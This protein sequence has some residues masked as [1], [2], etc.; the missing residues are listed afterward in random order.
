M[1]IAVILAVVLSLSGCAGPEGEP[2]AMGPPGEQGEQG[3]PGP[4]GEPGT[5]GVGLVTSTTCDVVV[6]LGNASWILN[7]ER[8][9]FADGAVLTNCRALN[10]Y[11]YNSDTFTW[12]GTQ[13][14]AVEGVC[15]VGGEVD[16][17]SGGFWDIRIVPPATQAVATY[18]DRDSTY[19]RRTFQMTC[20]RYP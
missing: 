11:Q 6:T 2:G 8:H 18:I 5:D 14:G 7:Y 10:F 3:P 17:A 4:Q 1:R 20:K 12:H 15:L 19:N 13:V 9:Q 16:A